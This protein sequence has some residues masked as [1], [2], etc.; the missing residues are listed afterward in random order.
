MRC[1]SAQGV[2]DMNAP[3]RERAYTPQEKCN[4]KGLLA[5]FQASQTF[6]VLVQASS[7]SRGIAGIGEAERLTQAIRRLVS[8]RNLAVKANKPVLPCGCESLTM[9][10]I[11][12]APSPTRMEPCVRGDPR[13]IARIPCPQTEFLAQK[14]HKQKKII[15]DKKA[16]AK[17][18]SLYDTM[19]DADRLLEQYG[20]PYSAFTATQ[21]TNFEII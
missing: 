19:Y 11:R 16:A 21:L 8:P 17:R 9:H 2:H 1:H 7:G 15:G 4:P 13:M 14:R 18:K 3:G 6:P 5:D 12:C 10:S 20:T